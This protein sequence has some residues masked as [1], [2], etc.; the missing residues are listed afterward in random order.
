M[1]AV[2]IW[3][4]AKVAAIKRV[5]RVRYVAT[6]QNAISRN[7]PCPC[8]SGRRYK[9]C[10]GAIETPP[11]NGQEDRRRNQ[12]HALLHEALAAQQAGRMDEALAGY[13]AV[14]VDEPDDFN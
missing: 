9:E 12:R 6:M 1:I 11:V 7:A 5:R 4:L 13:E 10:H 14:L 3:G 2:T 8:G